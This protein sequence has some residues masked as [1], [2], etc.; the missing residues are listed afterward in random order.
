MISWMIF[1][2]III[3]E[4][5]K[6]TIKIHDAIKIQKTS[7]IIYTNDNDIEKSVKTS[8]MTI[9]I[10]IDNQTL[11]VIDKKQIYLK[12][13]IEHTIYSNELIKL[14][15]TLNIV[16]AHFENTMMNIFIDNQTIIKIIK[17]FKQQSN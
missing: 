5:A 16:K 12:F 2:K 1:F 17:F 6:K 15:L 8:T 11:I 10:S 13:F 4:S 14:N 9:F 3:V 7:L